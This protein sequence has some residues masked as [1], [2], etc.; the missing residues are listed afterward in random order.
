MSRLQI[1]YRDIGCLRPYPQNPRQHSRNQIRQIAESIKEFGFA[2]P[3]LV[4][5]DGSIIAGHGRVEAAKTLGIGSIPTICVSGLTDAQKRALAIAD[6]RLAE[7]A[8]WDEQLLAQELK[9]L[10]EL[11]IDFDVTITGFE[12]AEI[13]ILIESIDP[14]EDV[15]EGDD[16]PPVEPD[17]PLVARPGDLWQLGPHRLLCA[18]ATQASS[19]EALMDG[20]PAQ[21]AFTDP[22]YNVKIDGHVCGSGAIKHEEFMMASG[23]MSEADFTAFLKATLSHQADHSI[24][25][26][27]H[28]VCM[29]WRHIHELLTAGRDIFSELKNVCV[30]NKSNGGMGSFYRSKHELVFVFKKGS[31]PHINNIELGR[32]GR[33]RSNV[34]DYAG[35]NSLGTDRL[36][37]LRSHPTVKPVAMV[38]DA[39]LDCSTR[40]GLVLDCFSGSGTTIVAAERTGRI[41]RAMELDPKYADVAIRRWE[42]YTG[43]RAVHVES[44]RRFEDIA[45][46][47]HHD[48]V[49]ECDVHPPHPIPPRRIEEDIKDAR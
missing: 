40:G 35:V 47:R 39:I 18:D 4:D 28:F 24:D 26:S 38:A 21:M 13:D 14:A 30:W 27:I 23:E 9:V 43:E 1:R 5:E 2:N 42:S 36:E 49:P 31:A 44:G 10:T 11:E 22:P 25:G 19:F 41:A 15:D 17:S 16:I 8:T 48:P 34:W 20:E 32:F 45:A 37:E 29:D 33:N 46:A 6:N 3:V 7:N 12:T